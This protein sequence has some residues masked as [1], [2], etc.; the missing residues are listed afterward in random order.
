MTFTAYRTPGSDCLNC[1]KLM[2]GATGA[3]GRTP[4]ADDVAMCLYCGH[5]MI[6]GDDLALRE[7]TDAEMID[8]AGDPELV[9]FSKA[10]AKA[11]ATWR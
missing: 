6:Y 10:R 11:R 4:K 1:G 9:A 3:G 5:V 8:I 7:P 2:T